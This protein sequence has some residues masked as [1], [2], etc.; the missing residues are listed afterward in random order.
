MVAQDISKV[1]VQG[2]EDTGYVDKIINGR[3]YPSGGAIVFT[4]ETD[5]VYAQALKQPVTVM[6]G[7]DGRYEI[8]RDM[9]SD[10]VVWNPWEEK[11]QSIADFGPDDGYKSMVC[12]EA[13]SVN[14][15]LNLEGGDTWEGGQRIRVL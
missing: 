9:L 10:V 2:L 11:A 8:T 3:K 4:G 7:G 13:G 14:G 12:V 5:R 1:A 15:W 6:E